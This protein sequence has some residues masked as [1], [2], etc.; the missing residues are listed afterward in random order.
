MKRLLVNI[1]GANGSGKSTIP[2]SMMDDPDMYIVEKP[3]KGKNKRVATVFP[4]YGWV[5]L[6]SYLTKTGGMDTFPN[7]AFTIKALDYVIKHFEDYD[8]VME[9]IMA[10]T[11]RSTY[12]NLYHRVEKEHPE[13]KVV[14]VNMLPPLDV[15]IQRVY[16]RNG[17]KPIKPE[18]IANKYKIV[19]KN[20]K[21]FKEEGFISIKVNNAKISKKGM[22]GAFLK[23]VNKYKEVYNAIE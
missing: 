19:E 1:R 15:C 14:I 9:G 3:Y 22:L 20:A 11:I 12:V 13:I 7:N 16:E 5:A 6:G 4:N 23:A 10:S 17:G 8:I 21:I 2:M 18:L